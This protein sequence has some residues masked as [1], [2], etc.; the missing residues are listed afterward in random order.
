MRVVTTGSPN[1]GHSVG[2][3]PEAEPMRIQD[4]VQDALQSGILNSWQERCIQ[5]L[6]QTRHF[7]SADLKALTVLT[8]SILS[9]QVQ[10]SSQTRSSH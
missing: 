10:E 2:V 3:H 9:G 4:I 7:N 5:L 6:L 1:L 8:N